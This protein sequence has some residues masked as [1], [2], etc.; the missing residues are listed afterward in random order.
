[1]RKG[2]DD[3]AVAALKTL[4]KLDPNFS[5]ENWSRTVGIAGQRYADIAAAIRAPGI[6][7]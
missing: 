3:I 6:V 2:E 1:M 5:T 7:P 4:R